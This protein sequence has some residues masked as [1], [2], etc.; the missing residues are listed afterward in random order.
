[1]SGHAFRDWLAANAQAGGDFVKEALSDDRLP[2]PADW[3]RLQSYLRMRGIPPEGMREAAFV[4]N[5][6]A[7]ARGL[8]EAGE[9]DLP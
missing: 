9:D 4:W 3:D 6:Y 2:D 7:R 8:E 1:M 5:H